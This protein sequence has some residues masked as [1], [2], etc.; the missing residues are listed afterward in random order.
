[1]VQEAGESSHWADQQ[2][3][4]RRPQIRSA[5][6]LARYLRARFDIKMGNVI[7]HAMANNSPYF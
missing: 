4:A 2:I 3:L 1:M 5:L 6:R 7:G